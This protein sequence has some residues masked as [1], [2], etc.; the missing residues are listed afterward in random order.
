MTHAQKLIHNAVPAAIYPGGGSAAR[1][2]TGFTGKSITI[3]FPCG[4]IIHYLASPQ[5]NNS[6][7]YDVS[8]HIVRHSLPLVG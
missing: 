4:Y 1:H 6:G 2:D 5:M 8:A 7:L 3:L